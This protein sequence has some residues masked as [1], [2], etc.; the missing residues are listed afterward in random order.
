LQ[1]GRKSARR[2][3]VGLC[4]FTAGPGFQNFLNGALV[5]TSIV[6]P[7][8]SNRHVAAG[9]AGRGGREHQLPTIINAKHG[10]IMKTLLAAATLAT[11]M[12]SS[13]FAQWS[14]KPGRYNGGAYDRAVNGGMASTPG[15]N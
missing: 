6:H 9:C 13:A 5:E 2:A 14:D 8:L 3:E 12:T 15:Q 1:I 4:Q 7:H 10:R 11:L